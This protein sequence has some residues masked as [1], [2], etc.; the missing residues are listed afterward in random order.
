[1]PDGGSKHG[2]SQRG[3]KGLIHDIFEVG[4]FN[5]TTPPGPMRGYLEPFLILET[6][7][8][9]I[10]VLKLLPGILETGELRIPSVPDAEESRISSVLA[11][12]E[13]R[14]PGVPNTGDLF[15]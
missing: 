9:V 8:G 10:Q 6:F 3:L 12:R 7:Q 4:I 11:T 1:M 13:L 5:Q 15:F 2:P 14:I